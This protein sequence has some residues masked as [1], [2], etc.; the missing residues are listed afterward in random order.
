MLGWHPLSLSD[1]GAE[2]LYADIAERRLRIS[3]L[4]RSP[5]TT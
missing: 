4:M 2:R 1:S 5:I 3:H